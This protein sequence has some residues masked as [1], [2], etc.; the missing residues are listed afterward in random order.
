MKQIV[1]Y[2]ALVLKIKGTSIPKPI[3]GIL[4]EHAAGEPFNKHVYNQIKK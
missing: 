1:V 3:S 2:K 4:P